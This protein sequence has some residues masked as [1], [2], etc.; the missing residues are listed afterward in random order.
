MDSSE[1]SASTSDNLL[2]LQDKYSLY[3]TPDIKTI[4]KILYGGPRSC[5]HVDEVWPNLFLGDMFMSHDRHGLWKMG[6]THILN[7][8]HGKICC[9]GSPD[10]YGTTVTY[11]G[12]PASDVPTFDISPFFYPA[13]EFIRQALDSGGK[14]FVNCAMGLSRSATL[15]L[16]YLMIHQHHTLLKAILKVKKSRWIFPNRGFLRQL[17][18]LDTELHSED[19]KEIRRIDSSQS[20]LH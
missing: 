16:V 6:I 20:W 12:I 3:E 11:K 9:Q 1:N 7:A 5:N 19:R 17:C 13:A 2:E 10:F 15:V 4:E 14:V 8:A 18:S